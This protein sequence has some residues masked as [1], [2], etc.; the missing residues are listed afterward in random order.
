MLLLAYSIL[1]KEYNLT[2][3]NHQKNATHV[4]DWSHEKKTWCC[5]HKGLGCSELS[6]RVVPSFCLEATG[7]GFVSFNDLRF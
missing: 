1:Y 3:L 2:R 5:N 6:H 7:L 4:A